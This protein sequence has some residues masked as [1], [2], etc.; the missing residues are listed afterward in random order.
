[1]KNELNGLTPSSDVITVRVSLKDDDYVKVG[2]YTEFYDLY[3]VRYRMNWRI[4][5][6]NKKRVG[7][8]RYDDKEVFCYRITNDGITI[9]DNFGNTVEL[10]QFDYIRII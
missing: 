3:S 5:V 4:K 8:L 7:C 6:L 9:E 1:M 2:E 10:I